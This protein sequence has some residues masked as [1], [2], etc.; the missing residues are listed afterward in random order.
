MT[1]YIIRRLLLIPV[2]LL[3]LSFGTA[4]VM[5]LTPGDVVDAR[6]QDG[7][8]PERAD[9][10]RE[11]L[12][13]N[14]PLLQAWWDWSWNSM[15]GDFGNSFVTDVPISKELQRRF[16][17]TF[18]LVVLT[19]LLQAAIAIPLGAIAGAHQ[20]G[21]VDHLIRIVSVIVLAVPSFVVAVAVL[22]FP[23]V[24][25]G[26]FPPFGY[27]SFQDDPIRNL[28]VFALPV[29]IGSLG[30]MATLI[31]LT[32]TEL[33]EVLRQDYI[34]TARA[35]GLLGRTVMQ[36][37]ALKNALIPVVTVLGLSFG[38]ALGGVVI[39]ESIFSL[40]GLGTYAL[41]AV[42]QEDYLVV[43]TFVVFA[44]FMFVSVNLGVDLLYAYLNPRIR[45]R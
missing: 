16:P 23:A 21:I 3:I 45:Y 30:L 2:T 22:S 38:G 12:G 5:R 8:T 4:T 9:A 31:R 43:Q 17:V 18:E 36:R 32:R 42:R 35:K 37:H 28:Q 39:I 14:K 34:R 24:W 29:I 20:N 33:L 1:V 13:L 15:R 44:G 7:Y 27:V 19:V 11:Q 6:L 10:L 26:W 25:W 41:S 40:P